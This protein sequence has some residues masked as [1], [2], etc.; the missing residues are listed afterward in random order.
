MAS[1]MALLKPHNRKPIHYRHIQCNGYL[2]EDNL[3]DIEAHLTDDKG[4][5][6]PTLQRGVLQPGELVHELWLRLTLDNQLVIQDVEA[7]MSITPFSICSQIEDNYKRLVG[8]QIGRGWTH[9]AKE[10]VGGVEGCS[11]LLELLRPMATT[12]IQTIYP[13]LNFSQDGRFP[14]SDNVLNSCHSFSDR[15]KVIKEF[16]PEKYQGQQLDVKEVND[17]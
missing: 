2:R 3:W 13:Y 6:F 14:I 10:L 5:P 8:L 17:E 15:N 7:A 4:Y 16:W 11:H 12:A 1:V 9:K